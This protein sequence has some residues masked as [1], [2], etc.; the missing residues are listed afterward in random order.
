MQRN[1]AGNFILLKKFLLRFVF[2]EIILVKSETYQKEGW[3]IL[4]EENSV[5]GFD[6]DNTNNLDSEEKFSIYHDK[7][8]AEN[9]IK[10]SAKELT[11]FAEL[12]MQDIPEPSEE[13]INRGVEKI[14]ERAFSAEKA[15]EPLEKGKAKKATLKVLFV[16]A[17]ISAVFFSCICA[18]GSRHNISIENGFVTFAKDTVKVVIFGDGKDKSIDVKTLTEDLEAHG[19]KDILL[20]QK[21]YDYRSSMPVYA[22]DEDAESNSVV[23]FELKKDDLI[24][25]FKLEK[26]VSESLPGNYYTGLN[27]YETVNCGELSIYVY[28]YK[29]G[30]SAINFEHNGY[31]YFIQSSLSVSDMVNTAQT[32]VNME[33]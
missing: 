23:M 33:E 25:S 27:N 8:N 19:F 5:I 15:V 11:D 29:A 12:F 30:V 32:I 21:L 13:E 31:D 17:L 3:F 16:A 18:V 22:D 4:E 1:N 28:E 24:Y 9:N 2:R 10:A 26:I 6:A 7:E 14:L 20:P